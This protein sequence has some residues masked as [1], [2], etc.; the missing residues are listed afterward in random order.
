VNGPAARSSRYPF[1]PDTLRP[2]QRAI[3][4]GYQGGYM[5]ISAVP[6][7]GKTFTLSLLA[8]R[9]ILSGALDIRQ[10]V[11]VVTVTHSAVDNFNRR[12]N[13]F[14]AKG[15]KTGL[16]LPG[17]GYRVRTLHGLANDI[18]RENPGKVQLAN[19][20][21]ILDE[22]ESN[23][24]REQ[25]AA[26]WLKSHPTFFDEY[27]DPELAPGKADQIRLQQYPQL[28]QGITSNIIRV[29]KDRELTP[30]ALQRR[31]KDLPERLPLLEMG[32]A[33]YQDY[34]R[35]LNYRGAI[36]FD[37]LIRLALAALRA[38]P[39][40]LERMRAQWPYI[41]EDEAQDSSR[42]QEEVLRLL[43]GPEG[44]WVR[45]GDPNQAIYETFTTADP[46]FLVNFIHSPGVMRKEL[47][48]SG[49]STLSIIQLANHLIDWC[50]RAHP[51]REAAGAL[52]APFIQPTGPGDPQ[53]NPPDEGSQI[54]LH[55]SKISPQEEIHR[56][57]LSL[58]NWQQAQDELPEENRETLVVLEH[59]N[60]R[61]S[62]IANALRKHNVD[63]VELL[64]TT[65]AT[66]HSAGALTYLLRALADPQSPHLLAR[67]Y[68]VWRRA[69]RTAQGGQ[70]A[71]LRD[72][73][74]RAAA[75]LR[76]L[77][78]VEDY[79]YPLPGEDWLEGSGLQESD[80]AVYERLDEFRGVV[81]RWHGAALL[82]ID[83]IILT[84]AQDVFREPADLAIAQKLAAVLRQ[85]SASNP[86]WYLPQMSDELENI[87]RDRR[88]FLGFSEDDT[89]FSPESYRG[90]IVITTMHK[91]K[92]LEWDRVY[93]LSCN[94]YIFP[95]GMPYDTYRSER[96]YFRDRVNLEAEA[97]AQL[98]AALSNDL[99]EWYEPGRAT[100][101]ARMNT[102]RERLRLLYVCVT[103]AR[104]ALIMTWNTGTRGEQLAAQPFLAMQEFREKQLV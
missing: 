61:A 40:L 79:L 47:P 75:H 14:L 57:V 68:S 39:S 77:P 62:E 65:T 45:V 22:T 90:R 54:H 13:E 103:R 28:V 93:M 44:N 58:V 5:G 101:K 87:A 59:S 17:L 18:I 80:P 10:E 95:S 46:Q 29:A 104:K 82:P 76:K 31:M 70:P 71:L 11:L 84:L 25:S 9:L 89:G 42:L 94:N 67:A 36:D 6:G 4:E 53:P 102:V 69:D 26:A 30:E 49:R 38:D 37:D 12:I 91:A 23:R 27:L 81:R 86:D 7:S 99:Y 63:P 35:A 85:K 83:Q 92:G 100:E 88:R 55:A 20:F 56:V 97:L 64:H 72:I 98:D 24:I 33:V 73:N 15:R 32:L 8:A 34:Q 66:R 74:N 43:A 96:W 3:L 60:H 78:Q 48:V 51:N 41:L 1:L 16:A 19:D 52:V 2:S 50:D 21:S